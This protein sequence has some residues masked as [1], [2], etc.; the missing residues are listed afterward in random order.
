MTRRELLDQDAE[1]P[2][3]LAD[4]LAQELRPAP[5]GVESD[6]AQGRVRQLDR[7]PEATRPR[8]RALHRS[9][10][11]RLRRMLGMVA[12]RALLD[13]DP[14]GTPPLDQEIDHPSQ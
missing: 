2:R 10:L 3:Q 13:P 12:S 14:Q 7:L 11:G 1:R 9:A 4:P 8:E 6:L 5:V